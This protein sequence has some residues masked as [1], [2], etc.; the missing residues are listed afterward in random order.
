M[1]KMREE[2]QQGRALNEALMTQM[3]A[4]REEVLASRVIR[5]NSGFV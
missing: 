5:Q 4:L 1:E 3:Q 2:L